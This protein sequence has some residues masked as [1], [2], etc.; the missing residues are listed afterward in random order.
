MVIELSPSQLEYLRL[1]PPGEA[2]AQALSDLLAKDNYLL[3]EDVSERSITCRFAMYLQSKLP[4]WNVDCEYNRDGSHP[5]KPYPDSENE[6][7]KIFIP[8]VIVHKRGRKGPN[9]LVMEFKKS[10]NSAG[11]DYDRRKLCCYKKSFDYAY[12][13]FIEVD[14]SGQKGVTALEWL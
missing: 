9:H 13:L 4:D 3:A 10:V 7:A 6:K 14:T 8:D 12:A 1:Y 2:V 5:K 11:R